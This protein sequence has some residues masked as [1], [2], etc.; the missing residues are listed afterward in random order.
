MRRLCKQLFPGAHSAMNRISTFHD[1]ISLQFHF[2]CLKSRFERSRHLLF[3]S[4]DTDTSKILDKVVLAVKSSWKKTQ[5]HLLFFTFLFQVS[6]IPAK[7][8]LRT[9]YGLLA[10]R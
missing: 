10:L 5:K 7:A 4:F 6:S 2:D 9:L 8:F 3:V 1:I